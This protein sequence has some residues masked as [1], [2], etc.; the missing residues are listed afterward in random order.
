VEYGLIL[1]MARDRL[2]T[3]RED[4]AKT[5]LLT[6]LTRPKLL[7][8]NLAL[9]KLMPGKR[10]PAFLSRAISGQAAEADRPEAQ[11]LANLPPLDH[12]ALPPVKGEVYLLEG[13]AMRVLFPRVHQV[14]RRL[15]R[16]AGFV[17]REVDQGCCG[18][19]HA[20]NGHLDDARVLAAELMGA[21][22]GDLPVIV[23]SAGC[24]STMK[25]YGHLFAHPEGPE[26]FAARVFDLSEF[27]VNNGLVE[28]LARAPGLAKKVTYHDACHLAHGQKIWEAPRTLIRSIPG[29]QYIEL[30]EADTCCGSAG[31]YNVTQPASARTMLD[32]K[33]KNVE[34]TGA[35]I[36]A[37]GNPG[38][39]AWIAQAAREKGRRVEVLH[40]AELLESA[41]NPI[42]PG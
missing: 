4:K 12:A 30:P 13:C 35:S 20:H 11:S 29:I 7:K 39:H 1:E 33:W 41:F 21:M 15:L 22:P 16:R 34:A 42:G 27:L 24:G 37:T 19:M 6:G 9:G 18:S 10:V 23:N 36:V 2:E 40:T 32:R 8:T 17:V 25:A 31:I 38:C 3:E 5:A 14:T 26:A 28:E